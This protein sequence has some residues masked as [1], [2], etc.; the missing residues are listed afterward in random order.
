M[1]ETEQTV[2]VQGATGTHL[3]LGSGEESGRCDQVVSSEVL[4]ERELELDIEVPPPE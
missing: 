1:T 3:A 2:Q 4:K